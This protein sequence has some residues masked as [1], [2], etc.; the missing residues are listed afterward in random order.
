MRESP[1]CRHIPTSRA[2]P[3]ITGVIETRSINFGRVFLRFHIKSPTSSTY[4]RH[5]CVVQVRDRPKRKD[6]SRNSPGVGVPGLTRNQYSTISVITQVLFEI[7]HGTFSH[8]ARAM[9]PCAIL[10]HMGYN[11]VR[12]QIETDHYLGRR[13][14]YLLDHGTSYREIQRITGVCYR[15]VGRY[16]QRRAVLIPV[17][18]PAKNELETQLDRDFKAFEMLQNK[19]TYDRYH[20]T[21]KLLEQARGK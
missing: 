16:S 12:G 17:F 11:G 15:S 13:V 2:S 18:P 4:M 19:L 8:H 14:D 5:V 9:G 6:L 20:D 21:L 10:I 1:R 7:N 3:L